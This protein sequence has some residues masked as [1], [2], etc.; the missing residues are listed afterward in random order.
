M[1]EE[2]DGGT[3]KRMTCLV[4]IFLVSVFFASTQDVIENPEKPLNEKA[5]RIL[6]LKE[7]LRITDENGAFFFRSPSNLKISVDGSMFI[8]DPYGNNFLNF[9]SDGKF[10]ENLYRKGEGPGEIQVQSF[11][12]MMILSSYLTRMRILYIYTSLAD[13]CY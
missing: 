12:S 2:N 5:G 10:L 6:R 13:L 1:S 4:I 8:A 7:E 9:S 11:P 3:M